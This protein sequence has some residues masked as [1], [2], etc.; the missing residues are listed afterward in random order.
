MP[1]ATTETGGPS[2]PVEPSIETQA[3]YAGAS[4]KWQTLGLQL[5]HSAWLQLPRKPGEEQVGTKFCQFS[6][7][8]A[9]LGHLMEFHGL[10]QHILKI[11]NDDILLAYMRETYHLYIKMIIITKRFQQPTC[12]LGF[13]HRKTERSKQ[14]LWYWHA[15]EEGKCFNGW[16]V[17]QRKK[18]DL[19][20]G[21]HQD[22][23]CI[24]HYKC[25]YSPRNT[26]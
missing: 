5:L 22:L 2:R 3:F 1:P 21:M 10:L 7:Q 25:G 8:R 24:F 11:P 19:V 9:N 6:T 4:G 13:L 12:C 20:I 23:R 17:N 14:C 18:P 26:S 15:N 16:S